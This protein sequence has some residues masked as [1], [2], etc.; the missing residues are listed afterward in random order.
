MRKLMIGLT[1]LLALTVA[2]FSGC[3]TAGS[4]DEDTA[5]VRFEL[6][7][8]PIEASGVKAVNIAVSAVSVNESGSAK[9]TDSS[10]KT[11]KLEPA[12]TANLLDLQGG[13][14]QA[15][16]DIG[17]TGGT[18][19]NQIRLTV[20]SVSVVE[21]DDSVHEATIPSATGFKIVNS[22]TVPRSGTITIAIDFDARKSIVKNAKGYLVKPAVR[23]VIS[24]EAGKITGS[25][26]TTQATAVYAY[27][28]GTWAAS[29]SAVAEDGSSFPNAYC[30]GI[31]KAE[32]TYV[33]A[34]MDAGT[35]D[36]VAV[37]A[38]GTV[39]GTLAGVTVTAGETTA[40]QNFP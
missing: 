13:V 31:V 4:D 9:D 17:I 23:A 27:A 2:V 33:L 3:D 15:L 32:G 30:A 24:G 40:S 16:G 20:D 5:T 11:I 19:I 28:T 22:F 6:T 34:F 29:E 1:V 36:L 38:A 26:G 39:A 25:I 7:D 8:S 12:V 37:N 14:V 10:W 35:Y 21:S 18:K